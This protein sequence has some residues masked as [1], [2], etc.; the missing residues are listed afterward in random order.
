[1]TGVLSRLFTVGRGDGRRMDYEEAKAL[2]ADD[3][4]AVRRG[5]R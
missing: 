4:G 1:M 3:D 2:A 5:R